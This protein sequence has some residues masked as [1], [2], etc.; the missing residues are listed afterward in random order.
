MPEQNVEKDTRQGTY[1]QGRYQGVL[2]KDHD[3]GLEWGAHLVGLLSAASIV[4]FLQSPPSNGP[5][6][7]KPQRRKYEVVWENNVVFMPFLMVQ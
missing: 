7:M 1:S 3:W 2:L 6:A 5:R 4:M